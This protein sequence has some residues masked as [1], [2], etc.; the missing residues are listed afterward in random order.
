MGFEKP[1]RTLFIVLGL[2]ASLR[3]LGTDFH[4]SMEFISHCLNSAII[5]LISWGFYN[6]TGD[7]SVLFDEMK[8]RFGLSVDMILFPFVSK[9]IRLIILALALTLVLSEWG[10]NIQMFITGLGLGGLAFSLAA[11]DAAS[12]II[13]GFVIVMEKPFNIGDWISTS[14]IEGVV[15][16]ISFRSTKIR[17][18]GQELITVPNSN[19]ANSPITNY[20][21]RGK[22]RVTFNLGLTY[23]TSKDKLN[24]CVE[25][26]KA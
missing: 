1:L 8:E 20:T 11:K 21:R 5:I 10:K 16:D 6:L 24:I 7:Y 12:N 15:E 2:Y 13:A 4:V 22:R 18:F 14:E 9:T 19:L 17:T 25:K 3:V 23:T 26:I